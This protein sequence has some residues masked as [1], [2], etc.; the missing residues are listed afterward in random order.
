VTVHVKKEITALQLFRI[1]PD[2]RNI[3][4]EEKK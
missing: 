1:G 3:L 4:L 2:T